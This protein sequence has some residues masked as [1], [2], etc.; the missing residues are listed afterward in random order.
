[1]Q[2]AMKAAVFALVIAVM[3]LSAY[4]SNIA[5]LLY[6]TTNYSNPCEYH[7]FNG[8]LTCLAAGTA[9]HDGIRPS[10]STFT[11]ENSEIGGYFLYN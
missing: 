5:V 10:Y 2:K 3:P 6:N 1:M 7:S 8:H 9:G 11:F 4:D